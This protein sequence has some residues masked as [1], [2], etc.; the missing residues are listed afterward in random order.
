MALVPNPESFIED[1][2]S[3]QVTSRGL[4]ERTARAYRFDLRLLFRWMES[5]ERAKENLDKSNLDK[6]NPYKEKTDKDCQQIRMR[7]DQNSQTT[8]GALP[9]LPP[10]IWEDRIEAYLE[11]LVREQG[12]RS[13]TICRKHLVFGYYLAYLKSRG[14]IE[15]IRP[16]RLPGQQPEPSPEA[17][18]TKREVD[19]FFQ[20]ID[21]E[22]EELDSDFRRRVCLR[23]QVMMELLFYCGIEVSELLRLE[24]SDYDR[25]TA[26]LLI[27]RKREKSRAVYLYSP[28][29]QKQMTLWLS[30]HGYFEH[31]EPYLNRM[32]LSKLGKP[33]SMKMVINIFD[34]YRRLAGIEK[35]CTPKDLKN[36]LGRYGE[37][38]VKERV[39][40]Q[41]QGDQ[42][43]FNPH[44]PIS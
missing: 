44:A 34:K 23:D 35:E 1:F 8:P 9:D 13:S 10:Y 4:D 43:N 5:V 19:A 16:L 36:S 40:M 28:M 27:R 41:G 30:E 32:F 17:F 33:L 20:A 2:I 31:G 24:L 7:E 15:N 11:H 3:T 42:A 38:M 25:K 12:R 29:L 21:R 22:Y 14:L 18:L 6:G 39:V 37:E 26:T